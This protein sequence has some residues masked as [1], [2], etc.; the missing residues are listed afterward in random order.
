[1][2]FFASQTD[3]SGNT[4][5]SGNVE[6]V[7]QNNAGNYV[8]KKQSDNQ[9]FIFPNV[10]TNTS[11]VLADV[12]GSLSNLQNPLTNAQGA[13]YFTTLNI[14][15]SDCPPVPGEICVQVESASQQGESFVVHTKEWL[16]IRTNSTS[17]K[18]GFFTQRK[19]ITRGFC[20]VNQ[21][22]SFQ[23]SLK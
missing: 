7:I 10:E 16:R 23:A 18:I 12:C 8:F 21:Y 15:S 9:D 6:V 14:S 13:T 1:M 17:G 5:N 4:V 22:L 19:K 2:T 3:C 20:G 11:G